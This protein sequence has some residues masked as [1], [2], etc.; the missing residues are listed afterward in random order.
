VITDARRAGRSLAADGWFVAVPSSA[1]REITVGL[2]LIV[3]RAIHVSAVAA[4]PSSA[5]TRGESGDQIAQISVGAL[6]P[7]GSG[8]HALTV[9]ATRATMKI[10]RVIDGSYSASALAPIPRTKQNPE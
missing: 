9:V 8:L 7:G 2:K 1:M 4:K 10:R 6:T 3:S 5:L